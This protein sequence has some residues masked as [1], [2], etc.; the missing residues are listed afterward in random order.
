VNFP[1][2]ALILFAHG[3]SVESANEAVRHVANS[4]AQA[5]GYLV[6]PSFLEGGKPDLPTAVR[7]VIDRGAN[8]IIV[9]PYFLTMGLHLNRD[10]PELVRRALL[11]HPTIRIEVTPPLD[12]HPAL[13]EILL[14]RAASALAQEP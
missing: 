8:R 2:T 6:C 3:S 4:M 14:D 5:G 13:V 11:E 7:D 10:L 1:S 9:I 12:G